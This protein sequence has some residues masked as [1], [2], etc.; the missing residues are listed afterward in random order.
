MSG[1]APHHGV[2]REPERARDPVSGVEADLP[3]TR[4]ALDAT[5]L[6]DGEAGSSLERVLRQLP[7]DAFAT[8]APGEATAHGHDAM[9]P[10]GSAAAKVLRRSRERL[11]R[12]LYVHA[13]ANGWP[14]PVM[15]WLGDRLC[16]AHQAR[17]AA[18]SRAA[19][20][21]VA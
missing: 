4:P 19:H 8:H 15:C 20:S 12:S 2:E 16:R 10:I 11:L 6:A 17:A 7:V 1:S 3:A 5:D 14:L 13:V 18:Y 21:E 9:L